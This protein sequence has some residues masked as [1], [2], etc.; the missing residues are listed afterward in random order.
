VPERLVA[1]WVRDYRRYGMASLQDALSRRLGVEFVQVVLT[2]PAR[3]VLRRVWLR[4]R[5]AFATEAAVRP[6]SLRRSNEDAPH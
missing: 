5:N 4:V 3:A 1:A 2:R 6:L